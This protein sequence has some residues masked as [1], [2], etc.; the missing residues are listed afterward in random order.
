MRGRA[1][2]S[3]FMEGGTITLG[4]EEHIR[5]HAPFLCQKSDGD[6]NACCPK[7]FSS[8]QKYA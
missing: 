4:G 3:Q 1:R 8:H 7:I 6:Q 5:R 2:T